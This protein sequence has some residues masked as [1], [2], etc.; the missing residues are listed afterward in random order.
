[1]PLPLGTDEAG[2]EMFSYIDGKVAAD[3][4]F[5]EDR[6]LLSAAG[7]IRRFQ[8]LSTDL[9]SPAG[10]CAGIEG[11]CHNDLS[12]CNFVFR[13]GLPVAMIDFDAVAPGS[14]GEKG[15]GGR[16]KP[17]GTTGSLSARYL[18]GWCCPTARPAPLR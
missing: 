17:P 4:G 5:Y 18:A 15:V 7:L 6:V 16:P 2:R 8:D 1:M 10:S 13:N 11:V 9:L 12:P 14:H 3:L